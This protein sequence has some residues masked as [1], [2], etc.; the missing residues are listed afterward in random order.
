M[1]AFGAD[2]DYWGFADTGNKL[3]GSTKNP[4]KEEAQ[5]EDSNGDIAASTMYDTKADISCTY[6]R[7]KDTAF[8]LYDTT[9]S[10]DFRLGTVIGG[11]V[12][13]SIAVDTN[14][15]E[16]PG[17]VISGVICATNDSL[18]QKYDPT[19]LEIAGTRK[20]TAIGFT[21]DSSTNLLSSS[22]TGTVQTA[23]VLDS[24]GAQACVDVYGGRIEGTN[25]LVGC[26]GQ[27]GG[28]I[29]TGWTLSGGPSEDEGNTQ[30]VGGSASVFKNLAKMA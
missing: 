20:A 29:D 14:N 7:C 18:V 13:T 17:I 27:P 28:A 30:Y 6:K 8:I 24:Q 11:Y 3:Q 26:T 4:T 1:S 2:T 10:I 22:V 19:D 12:I 23:I 16:R 15:K 21:V 5:C 9:S 25:E